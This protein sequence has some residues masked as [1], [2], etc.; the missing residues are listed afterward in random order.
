MA[1]L[2]APSLLEQQ[3]YTSDIYGAW[4]DRAVATEAPHAY[5]VT[6]A[7][8]ARDLLSFVEADARAK[9][10]DAEEAKL[11]AYGVSYGTVTGSTFA[12]MFPGRVGRMV[13]DGVV[14]AEEYY[15]NVWRENVEQMDEGVEAF[16]R[17]C[18]AAGEEK[19]AF[20]G[21]SAEDIMGRIDAV[22]AGLARHPVGFFSRARLVPVE[23]VSRRW[24]TTYEGLTLHLDP[25]LRPSFWPARPNHHLRPQ[26]PLH[27]RPVLPRPPLP[28]PCQRPLPARARQRH[29]P[30]G[31]IR[32][33]NRHLRRA[34]RHHVRGLA[35]AQQPHESGGVQVVRGV[36]EREEQVPRRLVGRVSGPRAVQGDASGDTGGDG[37]ERYDSQFYHLCKSCKT[38]CD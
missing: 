16:A 2:S 35:R 30:R 5:Y 14:N 3:F 24:S 13:L 36:H 4:C 11:W 20:W 7:A 17:L 15:A 22:M 37:C 21:A 18:H 6:T 31:P 26:S 28:Q 33:S 23:V 9:G 10:E 19:C 32:L 12:A 25:S 34:L 29:Q 27:L 38:D 8:A 1:N